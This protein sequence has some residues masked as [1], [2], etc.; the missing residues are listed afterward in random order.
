MLAIA[1]YNTFFFLY[2][3][4]R[5]K[6]YFITMFYV[7]SYIVVLARLVLAIITLIVAYNT[8]L[9]E[10]RSKLILISLA[11]EILATYSKIIMG[12]FQVAAM[13]ILTLQ[14]KQKWVEKIDTISFWLYF[15]VTAFNLLI[16]LG[17]ILFFFFYVRCVQN[18]SGESSS[19]QGTLDTGVKLN[20]ACFAI[21]SLLLV[22]TVVPLLSSLNT[23]KKGQMELTQGVKMLSAVFAIFTFCYVTRTFYDIFVPPTLNFPEIFSGICLPILWDF[24][25]IFLMFL[26]HLQN[27]RMLE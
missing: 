27:T 26:Y 9:A 8:Y 7:T 13:V 14:V 17:F 10:G 6:I 12:F 5:Y 23:L 20:A 22:I 1:L 24:V 16:V 15:G 25:P 11:I 3:Q 19:C 2:R 21:L 18:A 4:K